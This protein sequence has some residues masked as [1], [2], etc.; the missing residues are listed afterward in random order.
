MQVE[1]SNIKRSDQQTSTKQNRK[2]KNPQRH[3]RSKNWFQEGPNMVPRGAQEASK[4]TP[5]HKSNEEPNQDDHSTALDRQVWGGTPSLVPPHGDHFGTPKTFQTEP[6]TIPNQ[7][8]KS[9][10]EKNDPRRPRT[11]LATI[12]ARFGVPCGS[13]NVSKVV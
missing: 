4:A 1:K 13:E 9:R 3:P 2:T 10:G 5:N 7:S 12:L 6:K 11:R 8:E